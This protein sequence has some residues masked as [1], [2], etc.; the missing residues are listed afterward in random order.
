MG[1]HKWL[2]DEH[3][4]S[5]QAQI[6]LLVVLIGV[7]IIDSFVFKI[8]SLTYV[9]LFIRLSFSIVLIGL[10]ALFYNPID[11]LLKLMNSN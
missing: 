10:G 8:Y 3:P 1:E 4:K 5:D 6:I 2:G 11:W 7:W 9:P